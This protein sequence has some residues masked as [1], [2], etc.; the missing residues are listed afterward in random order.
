MVFQDLKLLARARIDN[1]ELPPCETVT[2][3]GTT[4]SGAK[5]ALCDAPI[6]EREVEYEVELARHRGM[7][8][9]FHIRC[10]NVWRDV[11]DELWPPEASPHGQTA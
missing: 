6:T 9:R 8:W 5:C 4:G 11:C 7:S 2:L 1:G 10:H 3:L